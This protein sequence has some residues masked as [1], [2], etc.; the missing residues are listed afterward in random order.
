MESKKSSSPNWFVWHFYQMPVFLFSVWKNYILFSLDFFS[1]P[2]LLATLF[3]PWRHYQWNYPRGFSFVE[4]ANTFISNLFSRVIGAI[5]RLV[6]IVI[7]I[8]VLALALV[9]GAI[10]IIGWVLLPF[11]I[12]FLAYNIFYYAI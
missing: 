8:V 7:S 5:C 12:I 11:I 3:S 2:L 1:A 10:I 9:A 4:Y 6:L